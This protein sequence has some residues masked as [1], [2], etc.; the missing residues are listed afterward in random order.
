MSKRMAGSVRVEASQCNGCGLCLGVCPAFVFEMIDAKAAVVRANWC[1]GCGQCGSVCPE[2]AIHPKGTKRDL[3]PS[4]PAV[5]PERLLMLLRERR[6]VRRYRHTPIPKTVLERILDAGRYGPT[7]RNSQNVNYVVLS[8]P[9][10]IETLR[11]MTIRFYEKILRRLRGR[12]GA[13]FL[14]LV[15]GRKLVESLR[16]SIPK[17]ELARERMGRGE[18]PLFYHAPALILV[19]GESW[20]TCSAFN[21]SVALY[22]CS[23]MAH[24]L[25]IGCCFNG[26]LVN[27]VNHD[28]QLKAWLE[29]PKDHQCYGAMTL[30]YQAVT[31]FRLP[32]RDPPKVKWR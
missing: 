25:G 9:E 13:F 12:I 5:S 26:Y 16:E 27:A 19:H 31:Y 4:S 23:L 29:I 15:A 20:D 18:D 28:R 11:K 6:S 1:I 17:A 14:S 24:T 8:S 2:E 32:D 30:G 22:H 10:E 3:P 21:G 7:G